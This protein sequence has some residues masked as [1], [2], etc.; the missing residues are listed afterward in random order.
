MAV[1]ARPAFDSAF[2]RQLFSRLTEIEAQARGEIAGEGSSPGAPPVRIEYAGGHRIAV[3][4]EAIMKH[5]AALN[6][7]LSRM[8][9]AAR[10]V[11]GDTP[12][13]DLHHAMHTLKASILFH[14]GGWDDKETERVRK[15]IEGAADA[16]TRRPEHE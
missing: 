5:E 8:D 14:R 3:E 9:M 7:A 11:S 15:I 13:S 10:A 2:C 16:I 4:A 6:S 12:P 1:P